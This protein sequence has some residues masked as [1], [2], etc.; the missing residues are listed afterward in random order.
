MQTGHITRVLDFNRK[1]KRGNQYSQNL[2]K[3]EQQYQ[4]SYQGQH[5]KQDRDE[6]QRFYAAGVVSLV[7]ALR[8]TSRRAGQILDSRV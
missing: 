7:N 2:I 4:V 1:Q 5:D 3:T 8:H 6:N